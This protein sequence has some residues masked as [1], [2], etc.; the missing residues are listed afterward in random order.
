MWV[1]YRKGMKHTHYFQ[2]IGASRTELKKT[3]DRLSVFPFRNHHVGDTK[4]NSLKL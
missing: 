3:K 4:G 1:S 2:K